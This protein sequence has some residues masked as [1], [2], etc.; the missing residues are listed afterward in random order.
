MNFNITISAA[1]IHGSIVIL[2]WLLGNYHWL[3][4]RNFAS[5]LLRYIIQIY[6]YQLMQVMRRAPLFHAVPCHRIVDEMLEILSTVFEE[7]ILKDISASVAIG[8]EV[9]KTT[10]VSVKKQLDVHLRYNFIQR[11]TTIKTLNNVEL[12]VFIVSLCSSDTW[13]ISG[14]GDSQRCQ[15]W[16]HHQSN[17]WGPQKIILPPRRFTAWGQMEQL[18]WLVWITNKNKVDIYCLKTKSWYKKCFVLK[19]G[20]WMEWPSSYR[21]NKV[22]FIY[23]AHFTRQVWTQCASRN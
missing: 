12:R 11:I 13:T 8:P 15:S 19:Q 18:S 6:H 20:E 17:R 7:P 14:P 23:I 3:C 10:D 9:D 22:K 2:S 16:H 4:Q 1:S 5:G 21:S